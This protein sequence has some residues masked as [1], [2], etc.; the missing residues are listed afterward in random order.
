MSQIIQ[1]LA[2]RHSSVDVRLH[3]AHEMAKDMK[4]ADPEWDPDDLAQYADTYFKG[5]EQIDDHT[6]VQTCLQGYL[7]G[8]AEQIHALISI[9]EL[10]RET[11]YATSLRA[12]WMEVGTPNPLIVTEDVITATRDSIVEGVESLRSRGFNG[13]YL[14]TNVQGAIDTDPRETYRGIRA[15]KHA[16]ARI[17]DYDHRVIIAYNAMAD[18]FAMMNEVEMAGTLLM[19]ERQSAWN[20]HPDSEQKA[21]YVENVRRQ[22]RLSYKD[23]NKGK[24]FVER[25][26]DMVIAYKRHARNFDAYRPLFPII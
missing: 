23:L 22:G 7:E 18:A 21:T 6:L 4:K 11:P 14:L 3:W 12:R 8:F 2:D 10:Q 9:F 13:E 1:S 16:L 20:R 25:G 17:A 19:Y 24:Y 15:K 5:H 26:K